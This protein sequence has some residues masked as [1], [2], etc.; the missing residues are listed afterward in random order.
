GHAHLVPS[1]SRAAVAAG[2]DGLI[3]ECHLDP[4]HAASDGAQSITPEILTD[5]MQ[6]L[7]RIAQAIDRD[8]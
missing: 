3:I 7:K 8:L 6:K 5:L 1:M 4:E 2:A